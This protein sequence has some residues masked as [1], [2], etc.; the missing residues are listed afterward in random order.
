MTKSANK[1]NSIPKTFKMGY[2][3]WYETCPPPFPSL[4]SKFIPTSIDIFLNAPIPGQNFMS[5]PH[6]WTKCVILSFCPKLVAPLPQIKGTPLWVFLVPS[7]IVQT[8]NNFT[9]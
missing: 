1:L 7:L 5:A 3:F 4:S 8:S 9:N 6:S 2:L